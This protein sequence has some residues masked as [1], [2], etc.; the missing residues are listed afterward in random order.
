MG[1]TMSTA[2]VAH[3]KQEIEGIVNIQIVEATNRQNYKVLRIPLTTYIPRQTYTVLRAPLTTYAPT[4][5]GLFEDSNTLQLTNVTIQTFEVFLNCLRGEVKKTWHDYDPNGKGPGLWRNVSDS[6][7]LLELE[8]RTL[9]WDFDAEDPLMWNKFQDPLWQRKPFKTF[10]PIW[11]PQSSRRSTTIRNSDTLRY[12][13]VDGYIDAVPE[14]AE[15][16]ASLPGRF[17]ADVIKRFKEDHPSTS[18]LANDCDY[19][20]HP[21]EVEKEQCEIMVDME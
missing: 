11:T 4:L 14:D 10:P 6:S 1:G 7:D 15:T 8:N 20:E 16:L 19:H 2:V 3:T 5:A 13:L 21:S 18:W 17:M 12:L 9:D